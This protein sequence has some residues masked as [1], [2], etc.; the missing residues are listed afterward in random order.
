[1]LTEK[2]IIEQSHRLN[3]TS[4]L[5]RVIS[6][7]IDLNQVFDTFS[8]ELRELVDFSHLFIGFIEGEQVRFIAVAATIATGLKAQTAWPLQNSATG[9]V[10]RHRQTLIEADLAQEGVF[11]LAD[12]KFKEGLR[13]SI[14]VPLFSKGEVFGSLN[15]S[16]LKPDAYGERDKEILEQLADQIAGAIQNA[17]LHSR[18]R[19]QSIELERQEKKWVDFINVITHELKTPLTSILASGGLLAE[20]LSGNKLGSEQR[21][22]QNI[23]HGAKTL[24]ARLSELLG[25][26]KTEEEKP[27]LRLQ[28]VDLKPLLESMEWQINPMIQ[29]KQQR[30]VLDLPDALPIVQADGQRLEQVLLNL[31]TN[32]SKFSPEGGQIILRARKLQDELVI[33]VEDHGIGIPKEQQARLFEPYYRVQQNRTYLP[34]SGLGLALAKRLVELHGGRIWVESEAGQG[35]IFSFS[36]PLWSRQPP[37][38]DQGRPVAKSKERAER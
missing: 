28:P 24:E 8:R 6:S 3:A 38:A 34:G 27:Q 1:K 19:T 9:W 21:L 7:D 35:S 33:A 5:A 32:A 15:L 30:L 14:H 20:E 13:S 37:A 16:S 22:I 18:E 25:M 23:I 11:P 17:V 4:R 10:A 26:A 31:L 2:K 12:S 36:L 29:D